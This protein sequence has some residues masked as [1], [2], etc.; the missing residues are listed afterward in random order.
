MDF[1]DIVRTLTRRWIPIVALTV[2]GLAAAATLVLFTT[3]QY[4]ASTNIFVSTSPAANAAEAF[5]GS[6]YT[7]QRIQS[8][9]DVVDSSVVLNPVIQELGLGESSAQLANRV[10]ATAVE[11]TVLMTVTVTDPSPTAAAKIANAVSASLRSVVVNKLET[12]TTTATGTSDA[13]V[14]LSVVRSATRPSAPSS[15]K[16]WLYLLV[17]GLGGLILGLVVAFAWQALDTRIHGE[18]EV[19]EISDSPILGGIAFDSAAKKQPLTVHAEPKSARAESF[20]SIRTNLAFLDFESRRRSFVVTSS[21]PGEGK[22]TAALNLAIAIADSGQRVVIIDAD[23]R[24]PQVANYLGIEGSVGLSDLLIGR[25]RLQDVIQPWGRNGTLFVIPSGKI[26]PNPSELLGS[27]TMEQLVATL[28]KEY[29]QVIIDA[30]PLLPVTDAAI[31]SRV[32][33]GALV[34]CSTRKTRAPQLTKA[35]ESLTNVEAS[36]FGIVLNMVHAKG[37]DSYGY[38]YGYEYAEAP[39]RNSAAK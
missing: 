23:L 20:R 26:P 28:T 11:N 19:R 36:I 17:G 18:R 29:D 15:P 38:Y 21:I 27:H 2:I 13:L 33:A 24:R 3:P 5:E 16:L 12:R 22:T 8:Y 31:L 6:T 30:P 4:Q 37:P 10:S 34:V 7:Q 14:R 1:I 32:T 35:L 39:K 25:A 9:V